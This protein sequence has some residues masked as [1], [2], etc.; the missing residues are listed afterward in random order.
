LHG[1]DCWD[2]TDDVWMHTNAVIITAPGNN[3]NPRVS[4]PAK[5]GGT[6]CALQL[7]S[8]YRSFPPSLSSCYHGKTSIRAGLSSILW[9]FGFSRIRTA[10][11]P[12]SRTPNKSHALKSNSYSVYFLKKKKQ[13]ETYGN[14][15]CCITNS[16]INSK[17][18]KKT[19]RV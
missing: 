4:T 3:S 17:T 6:A 1:G 13:G 12:F 19:H 11:L 9:L 2:L 14:T 15:V 10:I 7:P 18:L 16:N 5:L 8:P